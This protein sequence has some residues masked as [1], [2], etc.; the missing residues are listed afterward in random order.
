MENELLGCR[1]E[2]KEKKVKKS[3][4]GQSWQEKKHT[5]QN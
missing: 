1:G 4:V 2:K 3:R 5:L